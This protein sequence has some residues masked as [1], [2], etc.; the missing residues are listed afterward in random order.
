MDKNLVYD[1]NIFNLTVGEIL[2]HEKANDEEKDIL[3]KE[4]RQ[5]REKVIK[6]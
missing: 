6:L 5:L 2:N 3:R 1:S 4:I